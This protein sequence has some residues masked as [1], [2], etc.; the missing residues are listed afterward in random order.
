MKKRSYSAF[1]VLLSVFLVLTPIV[2]TAGGQTPEQEEAAAPKKKVVWKFASLSAPETPESKAMEMLCT[3]V[4]EKTNGDFT[5][6]FYPAGQLGSSSSVVLENLRMGA[7]QIHGNVSDWN[8]KLVQNWAIL[9]MPFMFKNKEHVQAFQQTD[10]Y[11]QMKDAMVEKAGLRVISDNWYRLPKVLLTKKPVLK[12]ED[13]KG[14]KLRMPEIETYFKTW[15]Y[16]GAHTVTIPWTEAYMALKTG[17]VDGMDS[18]VASVHGQK[19]YE[20]AQNILWTRHLIAP[21]DIL[22]NDKAYQPISDEYKS[23]LKESADEAGDYY[24]EL[25]VSSF[26]KDKQKMIAEGAVFRETDTD[27]FAEKAMELAKEQFEGRL[28]EEGLIDAVAAVRP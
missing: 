3:T 22:V 7:V 2:A 10:A 19:F 9:A 25:V 4:T 13:L 21:F 28:W 1:F 24:T 14:L 16:L 8:S 23:V 12:V 5:I 20:A 18:P 11:Q 15:E 6:N 27:P 17:T 26:E